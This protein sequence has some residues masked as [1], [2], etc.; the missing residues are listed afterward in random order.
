MALTD[1]QKQDLDSRLEGASIQF[2]SANKILCEIGDLSVLWDK[3]EMKIGD[4]FLEGSEVL[5]EDDEPIEEIRNIRNAL[6]PVLGETSGS[7]LQNLGAF[8]SEYWRVYWEYQLENCNDDSIDLVKRKW[9]SK[10]R[11]F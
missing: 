10:M 11:I 6:D 4:S 2:F 5:L 3:L 8:L 7:S 1:V 9:K